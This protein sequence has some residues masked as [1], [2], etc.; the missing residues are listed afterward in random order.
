MIHRQLVKRRSVRRAMSFARGP[1][2]A[3]LISS[4]PGLASAGEFDRSTLPAAVAGPARC[5]G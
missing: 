3:F 5:D 2:F 1:L 4:P